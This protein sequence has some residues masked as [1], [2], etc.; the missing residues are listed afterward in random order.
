[1]KKADDHPPPRPRPSRS[2]PPLAL[3]G[4]R[5]PCPKESAGGGTRPDEPTRSTC[6]ASSLPKGSSS[7]RTARTS[8]I[9]RSSTHLGPRRSA[10]RRPG[11]E[12][13]EEDPHRAGAASAANSRP[14]QWVGG[15]RQCTKPGSRGRCSPTGVTVTLP[16]GATTKSSK[17][18]TSRSTASAASVPAQLA[19]RGPGR[20]GG[21]PPTGFRPR[22]PTEVAEQVRLLRGLPH[23]DARE[24][25]GASI[26]RRLG[27]QKA[28]VRVQ[29]H[30]EGVSGGAHA[31]APGA[32]PEMEQPGVELAGSQ[33]LRSPRVRH[34]TSSG[35]AS[36]DGVRDGARSA[37]APA[38][39]RGAPRGVS[40]G[41]EPGADPTR[42]EPAGLASASSVGEEVAARRR[43]PA[44]HGTTS[45]ARKLL[46]AVGHR[47]SRRTR[48]EAPASGYAEHSRGGAAPS[49]PRG[50]PSRRCRPAPCPRAPL[51]SAGGRGSRSRASRR[52]S[53]R[54][55]LFAIIFRRM[56]R[57]PS[58]SPG[59]YVR[60]S[61]R[62]W[63]RCIDITSAP[64]VPSNGVS[65]R[66]RW[67][68]TRR[69]SRCRRARRRP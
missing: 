66:G 53:A 20:R 31:D 48:G 55:R 30:G 43:G 34:R 9:G 44:R 57:K 65:A 26:L 13:H 37:A 27:L 5:G 50:R 35:R 59:T 41:R 18:P 1:M 56:Q 11:G 58:E 47:R 45:A 39:P 62:G 6:G 32:N 19:D 12:V 40:R 51:P 69:A 22:G 3:S 68:G 16:A 8:R 7:S 25:A 28:G 17:T 46:D 29:L 10:R 49:G 60:G 14:L 33:P 61:A 24:G 64:D 67:G 23:E 52:R 63:R 38:G 2:R 36:G 4:C 54:P 15:A 42:P 21:R